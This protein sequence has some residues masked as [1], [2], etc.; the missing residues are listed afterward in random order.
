MAIGIATMGMFRGVNCDGC[1]PGVGPGERGS[2]VGGIH[3]PP[4]GPKCVVTVERI[5][6]DEEETNKYIRVMAIRTQNGEV[7]D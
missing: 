3:L 2:G 7:D 4:P 1:T 6:T 5:R